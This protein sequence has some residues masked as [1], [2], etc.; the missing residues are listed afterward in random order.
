LGKVFSRK[1]LRSCLRDDGGVAAIEA[2]FLFPLLMTIMCGTID[3]GAAL[4]TNLKVT[5]ACQIV[6]DLLA[7]EGTTNDAQIED[8]IIAGR[9]S[10]NPYKTDSYGIDIVGIRYTG[11]SLTPTVIWRETVNMEESETIV[12]RSA[13]LGRQDEGIIAVTVRYTFRPFFSGYIVGDIDMREEAFV[14]G[15]KGMFVEKV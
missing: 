12:E 15:R 14:R 7:R 10:L 4:V 8:A 3:I 2:G 6:G 13:G 11:S 1:L 9:L 5:N